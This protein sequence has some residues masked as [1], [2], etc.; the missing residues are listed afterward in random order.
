MTDERRF[1]H[2]PRC[3]TETN[4]NE[5]YRMPIQGDTPDANPADEAATPDRQMVNTEEWIRFLPC[6]CVVPPEEYVELFKERMGR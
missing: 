2:C 5:V 6:E 4:G 3:G 1:T